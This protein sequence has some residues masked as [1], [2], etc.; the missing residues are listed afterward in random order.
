VSASPSGFALVSGRLI[1]GAC[2]LASALI[3]AWMVVV[4]VAPDLNPLPLLP[5][6]DRLRTPTHLTVT[7]AALISAL[8]LAGS[9]WLLLARSRLAPLVFLLAGWGGVAFVVFAVWPGRRLEFMMKTAVTQAV[10]Q[11]APSDTTIWDLVPPA[12]WTWGTAFV[13]VWALLL[14]AGTA[15]VVFQRDAY[16]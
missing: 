2:L 10:R 7:A 11:G 5:F 4:R 14:L 12:A 8:L 1:A 9:G 3:L 13:V 16:R 6:F 15:H